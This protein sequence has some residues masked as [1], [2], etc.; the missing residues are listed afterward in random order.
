MWVYPLPGSPP[1]A[2]GLQA[3]SPPSQQHRGLGHLEAKLRVEKERS[4]NVQQANLREGDKT[5]NSHAKL[6]AYFC[7]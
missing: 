4:P 6:D 1:A 2:D 3:S 7:S 5:M